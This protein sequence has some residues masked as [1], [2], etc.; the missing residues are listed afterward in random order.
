[1]WNRLGEELRTKK[2][3][4]FDAHIDKYSTV[5]EHAGSSFC[6][7][8]STERGSIVYILTND[9][10]VGEDTTRVPM[11]GRSNIWSNPPY[12]R[13]DNLD[14]F[15][16]NKSSLTV[17]L[18]RMVNNL[19]SAVILSWKSMHPITTV[20]LV[21]HTDNTGAEKYN[22]GLGDSRAQVVKDELQRN[23]KGFMGK[24]LIVVE[25]SPG[26]SKPI[27]D[28]RISDGR[29]RNRRVEVF[30]TTGAIPPP[31]PPPINWREESEK[32]VRQIEEEAERRRRQQRYY[33][34]IPPAPRGKSLSQWLDKT[35]S[36][37][38]WVGRQIRDAVISGSCSGL[39][40][41]LTRAGAQLGDQQKENLRKQCKEAAK[42][43][44][45]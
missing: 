14:R 42:K 33:Q 11:R 40:V 6:S 13:F 45:R 36:P 8:Q 4:L 39:E 2:S 25:P 43:P 22:R 38:G 18:R 15:D 35:L 9:G 26:E 17:R 41:L 3:S 12:L 44:I 5:T 19:A 28:N 24:V 20:R 1:M 32:A 21:G 37:L 16:F 34:P 29:A 31:Q 7:C 10:G 23:L 30:I 27:A